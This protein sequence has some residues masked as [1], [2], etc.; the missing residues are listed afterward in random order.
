VR[1]TCGIQAQLLTAAN[2]SLSVRC[3]GLRPADVDDS[4]VKDRSLVRLWLMRQCVHIVPTE[5]LALYVSALGSSLN[6]IKRGWMERHGLQGEKVRMLVDAVVKALEAGP[7]TR[8]E[9]GQAV[10]ATV[11]HEHTRWVTH[12]CGGVL[13]RAC[14]EGAVCFDPL[15]GQR[16]TF[17]RRDEVVGDWDPPE[18][19]EARVR[20]TRRYLQ[21]FGPARLQDFVNWSATT[22]REFKPV[23]DTLGDDVVKL[24][25]EGGTLQMLE[26]DHE[27]ASSLEPGNATVIMLGN[28]DSYLLGHKERTQVVDEGHRKEVFRKAGWVSPVILVDGRCAGT[29]P[30]DKK[31]SRTAIEVRPL[32]GLPRETMASVRT[33]AD[34]LGRFWDTGIELTHPR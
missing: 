15:Q 2:L 13:T 16:A 25:H 19:M 27:I 20:L 7:L 4:F 12:S 28:F 31:A 29:W 32:S 30:H 14:H 18:E 6:R 21:A 5:D 11:G 1:D 10:E 3:R 34:D 23:W 9:L 24:E 8:E 22:V 17:V 26:E 33:E